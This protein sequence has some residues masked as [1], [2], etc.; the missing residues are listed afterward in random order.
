MVRQLGQASVGRHGMGRG[1]R[2]R[3][4][5]ICPRRAHAVCLV[6]RRMG[7]RDAGVGDGGGHGR[8][9]AARAS[10]D[11]RGF[12]DCRRPRS[13]SQGSGR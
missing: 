4:G 3:N 13:V 1:S 8:D 9:A 11:G 2:G 6:L 12:T 5:G 7:G 10:L